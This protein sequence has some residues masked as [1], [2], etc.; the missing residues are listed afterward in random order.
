MMMR[1]L[2]CRVTGEVPPSTNFGGF[3]LYQLRSLCASRTT[4]DSSL[5][6]TDIDLVH[7]QIS[8]EH[9]KDPVWARCLHGGAQRTAVLVERSSPVRSDNIS[10][11]E[12]PHSAGWAEDI[13]LCLRTLADTNPI[14]GQNSG[15][16]SF[17]LCNVGAFLNRSTLCATSC[18]IAIPVGRKVSSRVAGNHSR[19]GI[20]YLR[21]APSRDSCRALP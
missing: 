18:D 10:T 12:V 6:R 9:T 15:P 17:G 7:G 5:L 16:Q 13:L 21:Q 14:S 4:T 19:R 11:N 20:P 3:R 8:R 2:V 1:V